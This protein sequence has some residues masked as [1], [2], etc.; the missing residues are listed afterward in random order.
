MAETIFCYCCRLKHPKDQMRLYPTKRGP[1]WRCL[2]SIEGASR[3]IAERDAF[4]QQ[5]TVINSEQARLHAQYSLR[6]RH[7]D[8][9]R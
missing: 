8:V 5:Q 3:S 9:A 1:R 6:L 4:G 2:R 7:N